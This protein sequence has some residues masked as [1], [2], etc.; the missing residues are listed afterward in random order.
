MPSR[1]RSSKPPAWTFLTF[2]NGKSNPGAAIAAPVLIAGG[3]HE[4][5]H[6]G[7]AEIARAGA[8]DLWQPDI[9]WCGGITAGLRIVKMANELGI[10]VSPHRGGEVWGLH[11][12]T[13]TDCADLAEFHSDHIREERD[14]LWLN[15]PAPVG[16]YI[17]PTDAPGFGVELND[18]ML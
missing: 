10:P 6:Y 11:L 2:A 15:E 14:I 4:F 18:T 9:T 7:F 17:S 12:L 5:T 16:G 1:K 13:A 3:E 8:L